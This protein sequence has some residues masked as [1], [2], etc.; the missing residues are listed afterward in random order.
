[1]EIKA[2]VGCCQ[3]R[4]HRHIIWSQ[5]SLSFVLGSVQW[6][7]ITS[8]LTL[9]KK[10]LPLKIRVGTRYCA[11]K[12][13]SWCLLPWRGYAAPV[14][15]ENHHSFRNL[16]HQQWQNGLR[17]NSLFGPWNVMHIILIGC[18]LNRSMWNNS[19]GIY[20]NLLL[21]EVFIVIFSGTS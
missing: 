21:G 17:Q 7:K 8:V 10:L 2:Q 12:Y 19:W 9:V 6:S 14:H 4:I 20:M 16:E 15:V 11:T 1:M 3:S 18:F 5:W 13:S